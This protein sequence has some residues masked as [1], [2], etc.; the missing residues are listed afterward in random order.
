LKEKLQD[1]FNE[2]LSEWEDAESIV[3]NDR[4]INVEVDEYEELIQRKEL[5]IERF[6][7]AL[8]SK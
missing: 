4:S 5:Y 2:L 6:N 1:I 3:I 7:K 8:N